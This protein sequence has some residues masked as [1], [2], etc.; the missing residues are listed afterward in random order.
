MNNC[1]GRLHCVC[2]RQYRSHPYMSV[3]NLHDRRLNL[4]I[5]SDRLGTQ[6]RLFL[7]LETY[8]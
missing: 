8:F 5:H 2:S 1:N 6:V 3:P 4:E 7:I